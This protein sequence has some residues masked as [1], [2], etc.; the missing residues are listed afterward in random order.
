MKTLFAAVG[1]V[2]LLVA[3]TPS[4]PPD[5]TTTRRGLVNLSAQAFA[6]L[7]TFDGG[8]NTA[9]INGFEVA[10]ATAGDLTLYVDPIGSDSNPCTTFGDGGCLTIQGALR[11]VPPIVRDL[12]TIN[13]AA[14]NFAGFY[15]DGFNFTPRDVATLK[16]LAIQGTL[17]NVTPTTGSATGTLTSIVQPVLGSP[18][19]TVATDSTQSWTTDNL[20]GRFFVA[21]GGGGSGSVI[22]IISNTATTLT[23]VMGGAFPAFAPGTTYAIQTPATIINSGI[24]TPGGADAIG[25]TTNIGVWIGT[26]ISPRTNAANTIYLL[27]LATV[28]PVTAS[29]EVYNSR[30]LATR[31]DWGAPV[32]ISGDS[33]IR[34]TSSMI[35]GQVNL[36]D[37]AT[38]RFDN[39]YITVGGTAVTVI[40]A[41]RWHTVV[42][43]LV[44]CTGTI[45]LGGCVVVQDGAGT[46]GNGGTTTLNTGPEIIGPGAGACLQ[47]GS[48][49][50]VGINA[51]AA[52]TQSP[53]FATGRGFQVSNCSP[54]VAALNGAHVF[55]TS[56]QCLNT[57]TCFSITN[58]SRL[59]FMNGGTWT[60]ADAGTEISYDGITTTQAAFE[61]LGTKALSGPFGSYVTRP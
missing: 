26:N 9:R 11:K 56:G 25:L 50:S 43:H 61:A 27:N 15:I 55:V 31:C 48:T 19:F 16:G 54:G 2:A 46:V 17:A 7:K 4:P 10:S 60:N 42:K 47:V 29:L 44:E 38:G 12:V 45:F 6:G 32:A 1:V 35:R 37:T 52:Q 30:M 5:A 13:V 53:V 36:R 33:N 23:L 41:S 14:G 18:G 20:K 28:A 22:P 8:L 3:A 49:F 51:G 40:D 59:G 21:T 34:L 57:S 39:S 24:R 58:G